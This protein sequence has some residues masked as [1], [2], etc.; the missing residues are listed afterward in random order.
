MFPKMNSKNP[1]KWITVT[2]GKTDTPPKEYDISYFK[3]K[4][5]CFQCRTGKTFLLRLKQVR[6]RDKL[7]NEP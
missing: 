7:K 1:E 6:A 2:A 3:T 5:F 4:L